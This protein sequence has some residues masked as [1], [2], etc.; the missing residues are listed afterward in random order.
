MASK[1]FLLTLRHIALVSANAC[2]RGTHPHISKVLPYPKRNAHALTIPGLNQGGI[3]PKRD[4]DA[5]LVWPAKLQLPAGATIILDEATLD[6]GQLD[7]TGVKAMAAYH[8]VC[9][10]QVTSSTFLSLPEPSMP[11]PQPCRL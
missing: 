7:E 9:E 5:N 10:K 3:A 1:T 4:L 8:A 2:F 11:F 6:A